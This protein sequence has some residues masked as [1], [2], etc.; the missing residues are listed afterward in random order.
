MNNEYKIFIHLEKEDKSIIEDEID[1]KYLLDKKLIIEKDSK[2]FTDFV[3]EVR[4]PHNSYFSLPKNFDKSDKSNIELLKQVLIWFEE[5]KE[6]KWK[7]LLYNQ[8]FEPKAEG[9]F[10]SEKYFYKELK[11]YFLDYITYEFIYPLNKLKIHSG[12]PVSGGKLDVLASVQ[13]RKRFGTGFTYKVKDVKNSDDWMIDDVYYHTLETLMNKY[14]TESEK[15]DIVEM[16]KYLDDEGY[17]I[18]LNDSE[19]Q[20]SFNDKYGNL[21]SEEIIEAIHK[22][23]VGNI[24]YPIRDTLIDYYEGRKLVETK[25]TIKVFYSTNFEKVWEELVKT[26]LYNNKEFE[27]D[28]IEKYKN[29]ETISKWFPSNEIESKLSELSNKEAK[30][31]ESN[32]NII[33]WKERS[34][35]PDLFSYYEYKNGKIISFIGDAKYYNDINSDFGKEMSD[36][37]SVMKNK[38]PMC[39]F[40]CGNLTTVHRK[41][42]FEEKELI[43][44]SLSTEDAIRDAVDR[45]NG[46]ESTN[47]LRKVH[48]LID[49]YTSR[50]GPQF[51]GGF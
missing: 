15:R 35:E 24:H 40:C 41:R 34:L 1:Y 22:S 48:R 21:T 42:Q 8:Y 28:E 18:L 19:E 50:K 30:I 23:P 12:T 27:E 38:Y 17:H 20:I 47:V 29:V 51:K 4:T 37:N 7:S 39:I 16:K 14:G 33:E 45:K 49:K 6:P 3:G 44:F 11:S 9:S 36:Y 13:N 26:A 46:I 31:S 10:E 25:Y 43:I 32:P 5:I 2:I